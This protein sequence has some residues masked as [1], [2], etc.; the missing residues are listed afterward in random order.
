MRAQTTEAVWIYQR[1]ASSGKRILH[2]ILT[3]E[4]IERFSLAGL[5][6][7]GEQRG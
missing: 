5:L 4:D 6:Q 7:T 3:R 2:G 1:S